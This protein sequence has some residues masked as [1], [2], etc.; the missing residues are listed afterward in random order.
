VFKVTAAVV[1]CE[2][3]DDEEQLTHDSTLVGEV[4]LN[5]ADLNRGLLQGLKL[6]AALPS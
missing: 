6:V 3:D 5:V 4:A 2:H 1:S